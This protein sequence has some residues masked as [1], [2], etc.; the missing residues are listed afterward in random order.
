MEVCNLKLEKLDTPKKGV[1][2][3]IYI[4]REINV[5]THTPTDTISYN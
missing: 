5:A 3:I 4:L 2:F 1:R